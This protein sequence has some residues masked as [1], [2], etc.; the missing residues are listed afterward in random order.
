MFGGKFL[1][2]QQRVG[3]DFCASVHR[4]PSHIHLSMYPFLSNIQFIAV[5]NASAPD[6]TFFRLWNAMN[7]GARFKLTP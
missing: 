7:L 4:G 3:S 1:G 6:H 5:V 2:H